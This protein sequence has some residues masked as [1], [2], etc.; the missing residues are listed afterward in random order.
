MATAKER[1]ALR[2]HKALTEGGYLVKDK[3]K[4]FHRHECAVAWKAMEIAEGGASEAEVRLLALRSIYR[5]PKPL[6]GGGL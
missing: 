4:R 3:W 6:S 5:T 1:I 2:E